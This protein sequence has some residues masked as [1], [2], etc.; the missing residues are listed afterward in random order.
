MDFGEHNAQDL[1]DLGMFV[2]LQRLSIVPLDPEYPCSS[3][4]EQSVALKLPSLTSLRLGCIEEGEFVLS[5]PK[6]KAMSLDGIS[7]HIKV[8]DA[9]LTY[10]W[11][12]GSTDVQVDLSEDQLESLCTLIIKGRNEV[13]RHLAENICHMRNLKHLELLDFPSEHPTEPSGHPS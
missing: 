2:A 8:A 1:E 9:T 7:L 12:D 4:G 5:C 6:L 10:L 11:L 13:G 3:L